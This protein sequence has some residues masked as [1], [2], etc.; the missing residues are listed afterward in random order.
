MS[1]IVWYLFYW[2]HWIWPADTWCAAAYIHDICS[3]IYT[4]LGGTPD[5]FHIKPINGVDRDPYFGVSTHHDTV[6]RCFCALCVRPSTILLEAWRL[7]DDIS[8]SPYGMRLWLGIVSAWICSWCVNQS[9]ATWSVVWISKCT[10]FHWC[11]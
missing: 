1:I 2:T 3:I 10:Y 4:Y 6:R 5:F 8:D 11:T 7:S 9:K